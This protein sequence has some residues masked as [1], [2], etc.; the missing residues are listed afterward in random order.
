MVVFSAVVGRGEGNEGEDGASEREESGFT[1][2]DERRGSWVK[3]CCSLSEEKEEEAVVN[4]L[5]VLRPKLAERYGLVRGKRR[6]RERRGLRHWVNE[7]F[8]P[9]VAEFD[10]ENDRE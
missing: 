6:G 8:R 9:T 2:E 3:G 7:V 4:G 1:G 5:A 10:G